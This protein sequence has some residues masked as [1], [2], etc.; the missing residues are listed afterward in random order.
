MAQEDEH[1]VCVV[2]VLEAIPMADLDWDRL[3][4]GGQ[5]PCL[6]LGAERR[7]EPRKD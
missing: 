7:T 6:S 1:A 3:L 2:P 5:P 4:A